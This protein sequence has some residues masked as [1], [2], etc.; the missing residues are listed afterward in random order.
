MAANIADPRACQLNS[1]EVRKEMESS[2][3]HSNVLSVSD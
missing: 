2:A 3:R 1:I